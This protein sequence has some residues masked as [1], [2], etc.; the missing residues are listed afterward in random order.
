[1]CVRRR[2]KENLLMFTFTQHVS[3]SEQLP[4]GAHTICVCNRLLF[5]SKCTGF[6]VCLTHSDM[7]LSMRINQYEIH[8]ELPYLWYG[9][10][11]PPQKRFFERFEG[12]LVRRLL[13][14]IMG[15]I[16][17][18]LKILQNRSKNRF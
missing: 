2:L 10:L 14:L 9:V 6:T 3:S 4:L 5:Y 7:S 18:E 1:M 13:F 15:T 8:V 12:F 17:G 11:L 16:I